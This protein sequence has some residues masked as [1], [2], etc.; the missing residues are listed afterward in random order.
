MERVMTT[1]DRHS[2]YL[3]ALAKAHAELD[4]ILAT[5]EQLQIREGRL[6]E[7][8]QALEVLFE[9]GKEADSLDQKAPY[10]W[11]EPQIPGR[12]ESFPEPSHLPEN[13][14]PAKSSDPIQRRIND[15]LGSEAVA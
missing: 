14:I 11:V 8:A 13:L 5:Y 3:A 4:G 7:A 9:T 6:M 15:A 2:A 10:P 12:I 1:I